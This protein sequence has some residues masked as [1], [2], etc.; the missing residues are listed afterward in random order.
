MAS[1]HS[2]APFP[3]QPAGPPMTLGNMSELGNR[4]SAGDVKNKFFRER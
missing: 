1:C 2:G 4:R 3:K